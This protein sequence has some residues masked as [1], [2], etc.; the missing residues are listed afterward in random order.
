MQCYFSIVGKIRYN[1]CIGLIA[2]DKNENVLP[3]WERTKTHLL[4]TVTLLKYLLIMMIVIGGMRGQNENTS[5]YMDVFVNNFRNMVVVIMCNI[6][7]SAPKEP[8]W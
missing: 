8:Q 2:N 7:R 1:G 6:K 4:P 5:E 3:A